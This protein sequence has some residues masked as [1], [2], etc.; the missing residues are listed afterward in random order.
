MR[1]RYLQLSVLWAGLLVAL[2]A[3]SQSRP[4]GWEF[5]ADLI[6]ENQK[7]VHTNFGSDIALDTS[8][9][10]SLGAAFR[11]NPYAEMH[12]LLD[13]QSINYDAR[14]VRADIPNVSAHF[15]DKV[16]I[17]TPRV[18]GQFNFMD[19]PI[20]PFVSAG[21]GWSFVHASVPYGR[22]QVGCWWDPWWGYVCAPYGT[23]YSNDRFAYDIGAGVRWDISPGFGMRFAY[24]KHWVDLSGTAGTPN[25]DQFRIGAQFSF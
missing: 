3:Y 4:P 10:G 11:F 15:S 14:V 17:T 7:D 1:I 20:T 2:S 6:Y 23:S 21:V 9:G 19:S 22:T 24:E 18:V 13:L 16:E 12:F 8:W 25:L 5:R